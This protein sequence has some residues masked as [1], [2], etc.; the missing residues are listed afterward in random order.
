MKSRRNIQNP[1]AYRSLLTR[2]RAVSGPAGG[3]P[4]PRAAMES[5]RRQALRGAPARELLPETFAAVCSAS[6]LA[7]GL[8]PHDAQLLTALAMADGC[9]AEL[10]T[11][12]GKTLA[13][14]FTAAFAALSGRGVHVLTFNDYLA[15]RDALWME[16]VY[17]QLGMTAAFIREDTP[18]AQRKAAYEADVTYLTAREAGFDY[19]RGFLAFDPQELVQRPFYWAI[20]D[21]ADSILIDEA[22]IPLVA[23]GD[24]PSSVE[25]DRRIDR[26]V[27][28][29]QAGGDFTVDD[30]GS[31]VS[32][33]EAGASRLE[34][35]LG[36]C[37]LYRADEN[38]LLAKINLSLQA[39]CLLRRDADYIVRGGQ[40]FPV[41][42]FTGR[43]MKN[44]EWP[45]GLQAAV[46]QKE[47][48]APRTHGA[49]M[50]RITLRDFLSFYPH[51]CGMTGTA[52]SAAEEFGAFYRLR[53][54]V[55]PPNRP[56][57]RIDRPDV[58]F[59]DQKAKTDAVATEIRK[60]H[61]AGRPVLVGTRTIEE[62]EALAA[63]LPDL[64]GLMVLNAKSDGQEA[65]II[66]QA[67]KPG[68]VTISTNMAGRGVDIRLGAGNEEEY[69]RVCRL[70]GLYVIGTG[71][72]ESVRIDN[73]LRGRAG[74]QGD[75]GESRFFVSL[76]D[77]LMVKYRLKD[78]LPRSVRVAAGAAPLH[79]AALGRM[80]AH[81]Q[82]VCEG[83]TLDAKI[84]LAKYSA[85]AEEQRKIIYRKRMA[86]L[87][88]R[89]S[90]SVLEKQAP[91]EAEALLRQLPREEYTRARRAVE[92]FAV[93][94][95]WADHLVEFESAMDEVPVIGEVRGDP[96]STFNR[97]LIAAFD[98]LEAEIL[99]TVRE[100]FA[101][102]IIRDGKVDLPAMG[103]QGPSSTRTYLV[104]DGTETAGMAVGADLAGFVNLPF[105]LL[106]L[107]A[108]LFKN[109]GGGKKRGRPG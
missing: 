37:N 106:L 108:E 48:L 40:V 69:R 47:G 66:A 57:I 38:S 2:I 91:E 39:H 13:A 21:E 82:R 65:E 31:A 96:F 76:E 11:G 102:M 81:I 63:T 73:Q 68:A 27:A 44:R 3:I 5:L 24:L 6:R 62:S 56:C 64:P 26:A 54:A 61:A 34:Q 23:A 72:H 100:L 42:E 83:Q 95:C 89:E 98:R 20:V 51:L 22:R 55:V 10:P 12:E 109:K 50:N 85:V 103:V 33:T 90:L 45:E 78:C 59:A 46:E 25:T 105:Y 30:Y 41:D 74:R 7:L 29:L 49:V 77:D 97:R 43:V 99:R 8:E 14:V 80:I 18:P 104:S 1:S 17:G 58:I 75:P 53:V 93:S 94:R 32:L 101:R 52:R 60:A 86:I 19:L 71:R 107:A 92:L 67:G 36:V 4:A 87:T 9:V 88:G 16:P 15:R 70:G 28:A 79:N 35:A 84:M